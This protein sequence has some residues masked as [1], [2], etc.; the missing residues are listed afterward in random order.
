VIYADSWDEK[1]KTWIKPRGAEFERAERIKGFFNLPTWSEPDL[2]DLARYLGSS[3]TVAEEKGTQF[4]RISFTHG[5]PELALRL[6]RDVYSEASALLRE[7][8]RKEIAEQKR[9]LQERLDR[10]TRLDI[11]ATLRSLL[12]SL[13]QREMMMHGNLPF[14]A[15]IIDA[16]Y[17]SKHRSQPDKLRFLILPVMIAFALSVTGIVVIALMRSE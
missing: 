8:T 2:E 11:Q 16:P 1:T 17:I 9:H 5:N 14:A 7:T 3:F 6:L 10:E 12:G 15:R 4:R 13:E